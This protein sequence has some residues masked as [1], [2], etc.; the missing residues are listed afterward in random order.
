MTQTHAADSAEPTEEW[1]AVVQRSADL[2]RRDPAA[3]AASVRLSDFLLT[4]GLD[5]LSARRAALEQ[6]DPQGV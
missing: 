3:F 4:T 1:R 5:R 6:Y 2:C